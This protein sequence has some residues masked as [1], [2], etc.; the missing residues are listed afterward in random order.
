M[1][2]LVF[3]PVLQPILDNVRDMLLETQRM[4]GGNVGADVL[5]LAGNADTG[6]ADMRNAPSLLGK[7]KLLSVHLNIAALLHELTKRQRTVLC[8]FWAV[9]RG[10]GQSGVCRTSTER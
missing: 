4:T 1:S 8:T 10:V 6:C 3:E 2:Q 5:V 9:C 7:Q